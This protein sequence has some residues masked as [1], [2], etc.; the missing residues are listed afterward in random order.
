M[1]RVE[2]APAARKQ[3]KRL[4]K[5]VA[6]RV[7]DRLSELEINPR[8]PDCKKLKGSSS[9][10]RIRHGDWRVIYEIVDSQVL[11]MVVK[12]GHRSDCYRN[13]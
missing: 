11:V 12:V 10:Y 3:L 9:T 4:P 6:R 2:I 7:L 5:S 8:P 13:I 1:Y